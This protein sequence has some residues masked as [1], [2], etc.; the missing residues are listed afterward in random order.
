M[1]TL[2]FA[3][4]LPLLGFEGFNRSGPVQSAPVEGLAT[5]IPS[6]RPDPGIEVTEGLVN[7]PDISARFWFSPTDVSEATLVLPAPPCGTPAATAAPACLR[8]EVRTQPP[9]QNGFWRPVAPPP[10]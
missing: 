9:A 6:G 7:A 3:A 10:R 4:V 8:W 1:I 5:V 2:L